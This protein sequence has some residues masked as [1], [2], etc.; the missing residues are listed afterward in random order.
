M[1]RLNNILSIRDPGSFRDPSGFIF[2][3]DDELFRYISLEY[4]ETF[5]HLIS[6]GLY[7]KLCSES[8][9]I[10]H[11]EVNPSVVEANG[12]YK[13]LRPQ[14]VPFI[15][16]PYEWCFSQ[17]KDAALT[18]LKI[19][20]IA[21]GHG[22]S[23]KDSSVYNIQFIDGKPVLI[24]TL[25]FC[26]YQEGKPW[27]AYRQFCQHFLAP[28]ALMSLKD[29]RLGQLLRTYLDGIPLDMVNAML[30]TFLNFNVGL[31]LHLRIHAAT[32]RRYADSSLEQKVR[33]RKF[34]KQSFYGLIESLEK[35]VNSL[36]WEKNDRDW[37]KYYEHS[38]RDEKYLSEKRMFIEQYLSVVNPIGVWDFGANTGL[39]S[40]LSAHRWI[41]TISFDSDFRCVEDSYLQAKKNSEKTILPLYMDITNP[42][43]GVGWEHAERKSLVERG[44]TDLLLALAIVHHLAISHN[45][46]LS[47]IAAF[48]H[49]VCNWLIVEFVPKDDPMVRKL[50]RSRKDIFHGY[51]KE[52]FEM[53]FSSYFN[54][55]QNAH[56]GESKRTLYLMK[57]RGL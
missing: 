35:C 53:D 45:L 9:L 49:Q 32:Q 40:R 15:S 55:E 14:R 54:I 57:K 37:E 31:L 26:R 44:P 7:N 22:M 51:T 29:V 27:A 19:Q 10:S 20:R 46:P 38:Q 13:V 50:L 12:A 42:S 5:D 16:Y 3:H 4:R 56:I 1:N 43:P 47:M 28:L 2:Y 36:A 25:S 11:E 39:F 18:V 48:F 30:P 52:N 6:S 24:D 41:P 34:S 33:Q 17:F 8:L 21:L 23:L